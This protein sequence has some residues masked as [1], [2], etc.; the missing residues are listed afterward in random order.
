MGTHF[1]ILAW[2]ILWTEVHD[3]LQDTGIKT[4][5]KKKKYKEANWLSEEA[6]QVAV[7]KKKK[8]REVKSIGEN[9]RY[10]HLNSEL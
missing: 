1:S 3:I 9:E 6:L 2:R 8:N 4:I 5:P 7:G 10:K